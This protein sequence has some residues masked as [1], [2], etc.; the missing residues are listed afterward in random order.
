MKKLWTYILMPLSAIVML[1]SCIKESYDD[2]ERCKITF[3][4]VGDG[5]TDIFPQ[6]VNGVSLY[7]YDE[8]DNCL[9]TRSLDKSALEQ[10]QGVKLNLKPGRYRIVGI[11]NDFDLTEV[12]HHDCG[13]MSGVR[14]GHPDVEKD[15]V[16]GNDSLYLGT[17][18]F[19][20]PESYW[21]EHDVPFRSSHLKVSYTVKNYVD[22]KAEASPLS[23]HVCN[24]LPYT[25][26]TNKTVGDK[27]TYAPSFTRNGTDYNARF[28][29]MRHSADCDLCFDLKD[30]SGEVIHSLPLKDFLAEFTQI[31][32]TKQEVL[33]P[34]VVEFKSIGVTVTIPEWMVN[35]V[36]PDYGN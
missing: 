33:I 34:I 9:M 28:N 7:V 30:E 13:D 17:L 1:T 10:Y 29:I 27:I 21:C 16:P 15:F 23:L 18:V 4:Y 25:D 6:K 35:D 12:S 8:Q 36:T 20:V 11:G 14:F 32:V 22:T 26:F 3:S 5:T 31:D 2:C 19:D 24:S